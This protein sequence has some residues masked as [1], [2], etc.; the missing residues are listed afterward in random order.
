[1]ARRNGKCSAKNFPEKSEKELYNIVLLEYNNGPMRKNTPKP[2]IAKT[3]GKPRRKPGPKPQ[4][5][6]T[7]HIT[8]SIRLR[9]SEAKAW[10]TRAKANGQSL[11]AFLLEPRRRELKQ[12]GKP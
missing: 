12:E 8:L 9:P 1:M 10:K 4:P 3:T 2:I 7:S 5:D 11:A 6:S